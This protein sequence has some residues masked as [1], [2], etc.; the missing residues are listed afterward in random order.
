MAKRNY[1]QCPAC[2]I[3]FGP[4]RLPTTFPL[5]CPSCRE[6]LGIPASYKRVS[7][8]VGAVASVVISALVGFRGTDLWVCALVLWIPAFIASGALAGL[9]RSPRYIRS[10]GS[11]TSLSLFRKP[12]K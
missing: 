1:G 5:A 10:A 8:V 11:D 6:G 12:G 4:G 3:S 9:F 2:G 7:A